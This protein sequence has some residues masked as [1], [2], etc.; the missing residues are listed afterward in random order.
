MPTQTLDSHL[1]TLNAFSSVCVPADPLASA[2]FGV[3]DVAA[4]D[5]V[6][7]MAGGATDPFGMQVT[8]LYRQGQKMHAFNVKVVEQDGITLCNELDLQ[9]Q[10]LAYPDFATLYATAP[11]TASSLVGQM[12][13]G[14]IAPLDP[15]S[16]G[17]AGIRYLTVLGNFIVQLAYYNNFPEHTLRSA[18]LRFGSSD[19]IYTDVA[20]QIAAPNNRPPGF[21]GTATFV[22]AHDYV[23]YGYPLRKAVEDQY[24]D[25][26][27]EWQGGTSEASFTSLVTAWGNGSILTLGT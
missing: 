17:P 14:T 4:G 23:S 13:A 22:S 1:S 27:L 16:G 26:F 5:L 15:L 24:A 20:N 9:A 2:A 19:P 21:G 6:R 8:R 10:Q 7:V 18:L 25:S 11:A 12:I 3:P